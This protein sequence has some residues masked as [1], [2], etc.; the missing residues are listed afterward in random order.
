[1]AGMIWKK[2]LVICGAL[3]GCLLALILGGFCG[4]EFFDK[5]LSHPEIN[6]VGPGDGMGIVLLAIVFTIPLLVL[7]L[8]YWRRLYSRISN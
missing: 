8:L 4:V 3:I 7:N 5:F 6:S 1:M 2:L